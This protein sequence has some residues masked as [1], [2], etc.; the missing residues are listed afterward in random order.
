MSLLYIA[1]YT[2]RS[3][4]CKI[5]ATSLSVSA[6]CRR[7]SWTRSTEKV[8]AHPLALQRSIGPRLEKGADVGLR[9]RHA[10]S[11]VGRRGADP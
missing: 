6:G 1:L 11:T 3:L 8:R 9:G 10:G 7:V 2:K 4:F 5:A